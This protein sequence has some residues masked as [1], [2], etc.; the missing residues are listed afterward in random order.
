MN[1]EKLN[2]HKKIIDWLTDSNSCLKKVMYFL[3][4]ILWCGGVKIYVQ[5]CQNFSQTNIL[6]IEYLPTKPQTTHECWNFKFQIFLNPIQSNQI[7]FEKMSSF[8][9]PHT[10][11]FPSSSRLPKDPSNEFGK[12]GTFRQFESEFW[13]SISSIRFDNPDCFLVPRPTRIFEYA[14]QKIIKIGKNS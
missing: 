7:P 9:P 13:R 14:E 2:I 1:S 4:K 5:T 11:G 12:S 3:E 10:R 8:F 6:N